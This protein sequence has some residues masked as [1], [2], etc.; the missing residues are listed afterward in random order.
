MTRCTVLVIEDDLA[1]RRGLRDALRHEGYGVLEAGDAIEGQRLALTSEAALVLLDLVLPGGSGLGVLERIRDA[2]PGL[3]VIVLTA[4][5]GEDDRVRGLRLGADDYVVKP[6]SVRELLARVDSVL[7]RSPER[8]DGALS[9]L[10]PGGE[11]DLLRLEIRF[12][13]GTATALSPLEA[14]LL[15]YLAANSQRATS[16]E[17]L[18]QRIWKVNPR[19]VQTRSVDMA[20][21]R[22]RR[23]LRDDDDPPRLLLTVRG[24]GY[25]LA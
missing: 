8:T 22:L 2:R 12:A 23:K 17:E 5:G 19:Y 16:R 4:R 6:F 7:R 24:K 13:D 18:L 9:L 11:V 14:D 21:A 20:V 1:I 15:R 3:P 25:K 10:L